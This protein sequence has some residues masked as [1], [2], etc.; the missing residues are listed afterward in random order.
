MAQSS[1]GYPKSN[2]RWTEGHFHSGEGWDFGWGAPFQQAKQPGTRIRW[3]KWEDEPWREEGR[4]WTRSRQGYR[5]GSGGIL[6]GALIEIWESVYTKMRR[7]TIRILREETQKLQVLGE[8]AP[9]LSV[10]WPRKS[11]R[12]IKAK[13][14]PSAVINTGLIVQNILMNADWC[15][16]E[17]LS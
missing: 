7:K 5:E 6:L 11:T 4:G 2:L 12:F 8:A 17:Q 3:R 9:H 14:S 16:G 1:K 13:R 10:S 15:P